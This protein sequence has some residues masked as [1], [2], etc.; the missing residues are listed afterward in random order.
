LKVLNSTQRDAPLP[1][2]MELTPKGPEMYL[3]KPSTTEPIKQSDQHTAY[4][5]QTEEKNKRETKIDQH[6]PK[7]I[8]RIYQESVKNVPLLKYSW[9]LIS[10]ICILSF[11][12]Y[13]KLK[14]SDVFFYA[15]AVLFI[16]FLAFVFSFL[17]KTKDIIIRI[18]LCIFVYCIILTM[19]IA[20]LGFGS[21]IIWNKPSF[22]TRWF[23]D[24][25]MK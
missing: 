18:A 12:A 7:S 16:S 3:D 21:F 4:Y 13:A 2:E 11:S 14:N 6:Y 25:K 22:Y 1:E 5:H 23:P 9:I 15:F 17:S 10:T 8:L 19:G 24:Q 20:V